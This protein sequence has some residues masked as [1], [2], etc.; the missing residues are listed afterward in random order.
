MGVSPSASHIP[1]LGPSLLEMEMEA[2]I[3]NY[4][5]VVIALDKTYRRV[6]W[7]VFLFFFFF[8]I[9]SQLLLL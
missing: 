4:R 9:K 5:H 3:Y 8:R 6:R 2:V 1:V 7:Y